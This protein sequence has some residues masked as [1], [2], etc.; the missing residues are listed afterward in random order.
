MYVNRHS[1][2][3]RVVKKYKNFCELNQIIL[4]IIYIDIY[5]QILLTHV[6]YK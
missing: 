5:G 1:L 6:Q 3:S 2:L 4:I